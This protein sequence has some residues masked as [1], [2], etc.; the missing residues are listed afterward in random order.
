MSTPEDLAQVLALRQQIAKSSVKKYQAMQ[1]AVCS[2]GRARGMFMFYG[3]NRTGRWA[4]RI[5][6]L[7][8]LPQNHM[9]DLAQARELVRL[10]DYESMQM[11]YNDIPDALSQ[12]VRTA[13]IPRPG[14]KFYVADFSAIEACVIAHL[15]GEAWRED[16]FQRGGDIYCQSASQM[17]GVSVEK[18]G[19]NA[20][21]RQKR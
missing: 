1:N 20:H 8:N 9:P 10:G 16:L 14:F 19:V 21:L 3:A 7:Q 5:I 13:F 17:F 12:L 6:Q 2:D 18:H 11:L 4:R 15:A